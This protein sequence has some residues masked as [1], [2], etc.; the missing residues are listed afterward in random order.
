[1]SPSLGQEDPLEEGLETH[2][3]NGTWKDLATL[4]AEKELLFW[5]LKFSIMHQK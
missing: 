4:L 3:K 5:L 1:M 2:F